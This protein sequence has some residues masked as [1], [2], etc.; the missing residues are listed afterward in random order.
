[1][2]E[3]AKFFEFSSYSFSPSKKGLNF[4]YKTELTN[5]RKLVFEEKIILPKA[6]D[7]K[8][9]PKGL[10][11]NLFKSLH[12]ILGIS[13][14]KLYCP[15]RIIVKKPL[16]K[17]E[18]DFWQTVYSRGLG[19]F[20]YRN[21]L[22]PKKLAKF[23]Y[24]KKLR[25]KSGI[26]FLCGRIKIQH[27]VKPK[28]KDRV[29]VG[30]GGGKDSIVAIELLKKQNFDITGFVVETQKKSE[31]IK[32]VLRQSK[33]P[34]IKIKR[35]LDEKLFKPIPGAFYGHI[36]ISAI[37][38]FLGLLA[39][40]LYDYSDVIV[41]N[42][43]SS[44]FGNVKYKGKEINHQ[45]S[46]SYE[47]ECLFQN[48]IKN[49]ISPN[50]RYFSILRPFYEIRI[51]KMFSRLKQYFPYFSSCN[52]NFK[53]NKDK[54]NSLWCCKCPKCLFMFILL[55]PFIKKNGLLKIF[56]KNLYNEQ[57]LLPIFA[58]ILGL[59]KMK[60]FDCVGT[61]DEA[62]AAL[63]LAKDKF[64]ETI[65]VKKLL[66][67]IA[68]NV[69]RGNLFKKVFSASP[70]LNIPAGFRFLGMEKILILG[71]GK[72]GKT[73]RKYLKNKFPEAKIGIADQEQGSNYL[74]KQR[75][76]D[77][78]V[79]TPGISKQKVFIQYT[80]ATNIFF[81]QVKNKIIAVTGSKGKSTTASLIYEI[82]RAGGKK[83]KLLGNI[84]HP[85]LEALLKPINRGEV[86]VLELSSYQLDD[87]GFSP[88]IAVI[89]NLFPEH[90][91]YHCGLNDYFEAKKNII[92]FQGKNDFFVYNPKVRELKHWAKEGIAKPVAFAKKIP[93]K[94]SEMSLR[95]EHNQDNI[96]SALAVA[97]LFKIP[98]QTIKRA[99]K[100][101]K[102]LPHRLEFVGEFKG[103]KF[104]NDAISTAP[105]STIMAIRTIPDIST[106]FLGGKDRGYNF[107]KLVSVLKKYK[108]KNIVLFPDSGEKILKN[109][110]GFNV[111]NTSKMEKAVKFAY[112]NTPKGKTCLLSTAS[113]SYSLWKDFEEK[114]EQFK[115]YVKKFGKK[116]L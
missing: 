51:V 1:M 32:N 68:I 3:K 11:D 72:E 9:I 111:L 55:A 38:G 8:R 93:L 46:K 17:D 48:Y 61:F 44:N 26:E 29:L 49:F 104:Y 96:K 66:P 27:L 65:V 90:M 100:R 6:L 84:G 21:N 14:Y 97:A 41:A 24:S 101:F 92:K 112:K 50:I 110:Q 108:I 115:Y 106:I 81:S 42:E 15:E 5:G 98:K 22:N 102:P 69:K 4:K 85:M 60:P 52:R 12:L 67:K 13:Y 18:A 87:L 35:I 30:V 78:A 71:Y 43:Y 88:H 19:E 23:P 74:K 107:S 75:N 2:Q 79:K 94:I 53:V 103:I 45:W 59:G 73:T 105:E 116:T 109:K 91:D 80:T 63:Y 64:K 36:P 10:S 83:V 57:N 76:F 86:F 31:V 16:S 114:G 62:Q 37:Y 25:I 56:K 89:T 70:T 40:V 95:G 82:L 58:E 20:F 113:P 7:L 77:I 39:A 33:I 28:I 47:F 54:N 34:C 99:L